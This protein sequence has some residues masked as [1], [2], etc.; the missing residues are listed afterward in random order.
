MI[1]SMPVDETPPGAASAQPT[2]LTTPYKDRSS[3]L[4]VFGVLTVLLGC[5]A[6]LGYDFGKHW[7]VLAQYSFITVDRPLA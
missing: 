3:G 4:I 7:G 6:G 1:S 2:P 5:L